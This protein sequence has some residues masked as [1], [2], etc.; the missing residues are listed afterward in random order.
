M[1]NNIEQIIENRDMALNLCA[2]MSEKLKILSEHVCIM[3]GKL[4]LKNHNL[5]KE[6]LKKVSECLEVYTHETQY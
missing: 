5:T 2:S 4:A 3:N 6:E 1:G